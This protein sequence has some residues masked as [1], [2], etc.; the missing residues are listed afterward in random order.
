MS[1]IKLVFIIPL[2]VTLLALPL[3]GGCAKPEE[4]A[5]KIGVAIDTSGVAAG[6]AYP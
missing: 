3:L 5:I 6:W 1:R 2:V 4:K